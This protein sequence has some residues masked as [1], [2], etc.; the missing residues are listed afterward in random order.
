MRTIR[1]IETINSLLIT[2]LDSL[3]VIPVDGNEW[4]EKLLKNSR[5]PAIRLSGPSGNILTWSDI[6]NDDDALKDAINEAIDLKSAITRLIDDTVTGDV[7]IAISAAS[8]TSAAEHPADPIE[9]LHRL[10]RAHNGRPVR[11]GIMDGAKRSAS[12]HTSDDFISFEENEGVL[13]IYFSSEDYARSFI[14]LFEAD[15]R[16][17]DAINALLYY[18]Y[19]RAETGNHEYAGH[20]TGQRYNHLMQRLSEVSVLSG[21]NIF[22]LSQESILDETTEAATHISWT[23]SDITGVVE[24]VGLKVG[25]WVTACQYRP[26]RVRARLH[27]PDEFKHK[28]PGRAE[29]YC[30]YAYKD[31]PNRSRRVSLRWNP[32][33][34]TY[35][36]YMPCLK[37]GYLEFNVYTVIKKDT[38]GRE[39][40]AFWAPGEATEWGTEDTWK[41]G[42]CHV[43]VDPWWFHHEPMAVLFGRRARFEG[44]PD[45]HIADLADI[46]RAILDPEHGIAKMGIRKVM[47]MP[48]GVASRDIENGYEHHSPYAP[49]SRTAFDPDLLVLDDIEDEGMTIGEKYRSFREKLQKDGDEARIAEYRRFCGLKTIQAYAI[50][51][52]GGRPEINERYAFNG[53]REQIAYDKAKLSTIRQGEW[54][55]LTNRE[56]LDFILYEQFCIYEQLKRLASDLERYGIDL[57]FDIGFYCFTDS[58]EA[59]DELYSF[60]RSFKRSMGKWQHPA[61]LVNK[62]GPEQMEVQEGLLEYD[63]AAMNKT[64]HPSIAMPE[65]EMFPL[66]TEPI[67]LLMGMVGF[68]FMRGDAFHMFF[69]KK[70]PEEARECFDLIVKTVRGYGAVI[71]PEQL[72]ASVPAEAVGR[73]WE[74][75]P[76]ICDARAWNPPDASILWEFE[77]TKRVYAYSDVT[78]DTSAVEFGST[79]DRPRPAALMRRFDVSVVTR[80]RIWRSDKP[81]LVHGDWKAYGYGGESVDK[82]RINTPGFTGSWGPQ[83]ALDG[84]SLITGLPEDIARAIAIRRARPELF[85]PKTYSQI[86]AHA[87]HA[88][89]VAAFARMQGGKGLIF[90]NDLSKEKRDSTR[91]HIKVPPDWFTGNGLNPNRPF[92]IRDIWHNEWVELTPT[93]RQGNDVWFTMTLRSDGC[94]VLELMPES[95]KRADAINGRKLREMLGRSFDYARDQGEEIATKIHVKERPSDEKGPIYY[96]VTDDAD[97]PTL[98][99]VTESASGDILIAADS[100]TTGEHLNLKSCRMVKLSGQ[101]AEDFDAFALTFNGNAYLFLLGNNQAGTI[102]PES[103]AFLPGSEDDPELTGEYVV[104]DPFQKKAYHKA[105]RDELSTDK[106][107]KVGIPAGGQKLILI[108]IKKVSRPAILQASWE[109]LNGG[110]AREDGATDRVIENLDK[111]AELLDLPKGSIVHMI[112]AEPRGRLGGELNNK[113]VDPDDNIY[114]IE[115][116][117]DGKEYRAVVYDTARP[118]RHGRVASAFHP[119]DLADDMVLRDMTRLKKEVRGGSLELMLNITRHLAPDSPDVL[120]RPW[121]CEPY[122]YVPD[123][124]REAERVTIPSDYA[125]HRL[126]MEVAGERVWG[127]AEVKR[128]SAVILYGQYD[129]DARRKLRERGFAF[130]QDPEHPDD[131][132]RIRI[133]IRHTSAVGSLTDSAALDLFYSETVDFIRGIIKKCIAAGHTIFRFDLGWLFPPDSVQNIRKGLPRITAIT[134]EYSALDALTRRHI[135]AGFDGLYNQGPSTFDFLPVEQEELFQAIRKYFAHGD[136]SLP[137]QQYLYDRQIMMA[138]A[139]FVNNI[140]NHDEDPVVHIFNGNREKYLAMLAIVAFLPGHLL[141]NMPDVLGWEWEGRWE[142][143]E[144]SRTRY[145]IQ[146]ELPFKEIARIAG[147]KNSWLSGRT[148]EGLPFDPNIAEGV[149]QILAHRGRDIFTKNAGYRVPDREREAVIFQRYGDGKLAIPVVNF[150]PN[151]VEVDVTKGLDIDG[152]DPVRD[153]LKPWEARV[154]YLEDGPTGPTLS[155]HSLVNGDPEA[156]AT[157]SAGSEG[158]GRQGSPAGFIGG[159]AGTS[160]A[161]ET[162]GEAGRLWEFLWKMFG[163]TRKDVQIELTTWCPLGCAHCLAW[164]KMC[165]LHRDDKS[166]QMDYDLAVSIVKSFKGAQKLCFTGGEPLV[167]GQSREDFAAGKFSEDFMKLIELASTMVDEVVIDTCGASIP[168][169]GDIEKDLGFFDKFKELNNVTFEISLDDE[170][171]QRIKALYGK[172]LKDIVA[173]CEMAHKRGRKMDLF[174]RLV[175]KK[176][177]NMNVLRMLIVE[178][179]LIAIQKYMLAFKKVVA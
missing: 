78:G 33:T 177:Q 6:A 67:H 142:G 166:P 100:I 97:A 159:P 36:G 170:H 117:H 138:L 147:E 84:E 136:S 173:R 139:I 149:K 140:S 96:E 164:D 43:R 154:Y 137:I 4:L 108:P 114:K 25:E 13:I 113:N 109:G 1:A 111:V 51:V 127:D 119:T 68:N 71:M 161:T 10:E 75:G 165:A 57:G 160:S 162:E 65:D 175:L 103:M 155:R 24:N 72:G 14:E 145:D 132:E 62:D 86:Q 144:W 92:L 66:F 41:K 151:E 125:D 179:L 19:A 21:N 110:K 167:Y 2:S 168:V 98:S 17:E 106:P 45:D 69:S 46:R 12:L 11:F 79:H 126:F 104:F 76:L 58:A 9:R 122:M 163:H 89:E 143:G 88:D 80:A 112:G 34:E 123:E 178:N 115:F 64:P 128:S 152:L 48:F 30:E 129:D 81:A 61:W 55:G 101:P 27:L 23:R 83:P 47:L 73:L 85:G 5:A 120:K 131:P 42:R 22:K 90:V 38:E 95:M 15:G 32:E 169:T 31:N 172:E 91:E 153:T 53:W 70:Y 3:R 121:L 18:A 141:L 50:Y 176:K 150:S 174:V 59:S 49:I 7:P 16:T 99:D 157:S 94:R 105:S 102:D 28:F 54:Q 77:D 44:Q 118:R 158:S 171:A 130:G 74:T 35:E 87:D 39:V 146:R 124:W 8:T 37:S 52:V 82:D 107:L 133:L 134:E 116:T 20:E 63:F 93:G 29:V 26:L 135:D 40:R 60:N 56:R 156:A 148:F